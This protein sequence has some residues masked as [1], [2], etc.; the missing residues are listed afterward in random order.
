V[1]DKNIKVLM[2]NAR[3]WGVHGVIG[4][5]GHNSDDD[6]QE[7]A[8]FFIFVYIFFCFFFFFFVL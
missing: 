7:R 5:V 3:G 8:W 1:S 2:S 6:N 4:G